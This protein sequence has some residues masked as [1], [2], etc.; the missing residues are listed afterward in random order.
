MLKQ[1]MENR[2]SGTS[3]NGRFQMKVMAQKY[4]GWSQQRVGGAS[5]VPQPHKV[6]GASRDWA[7]PAVPQPQRVGGASGVRQP[8]RVGGAKRVPQPQRVGGASREWAEPAE[9]GRSQKSPAATESGRSQQSPAANREW[10]EPADSGR[11]QKSPA[12]TESGRSQQR[13]GG[14]MLSLVW[15]LILMMMKMMKAGEVIMVHKRSGDSVVLPSGQPRGDVRWTQQN[16]LLTRTTTRCH[17]GRCEL[18]S[19]GSLRFSRLQAEDTG[20][21]TLE[22][23]D[24]AGNKKEKK[25]FVLQV[26]GETP[27]NKN[28]PPPDGSKH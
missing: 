18:L 8:Q 7:D 14:A 28:R 27:A 26:T 20:N 22:V 15:L 25:V 24:E 1:L 16:L 19:D 21:Y 4:S 3:M 2:Q 6:G 5:R 23:F 12:A 11:S 10:A 17:H 13:V 9:S